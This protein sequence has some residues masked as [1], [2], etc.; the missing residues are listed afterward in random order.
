MEGQGLVNQPSKMLTPLSAAQ[1]NIVCNVTVPN[2]PSRGGIYFFTPPNVD[3]PWDVLGP[4]EDGRCD[5]VG[6]LRP[7]LPRLDTSCCPELPGEGAN[8]PLGGQEVTH[9]AS[10]S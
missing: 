5:S 2:L 3:Q 9:T 10:P 6:V 1:A 7:V 8:R 4:K